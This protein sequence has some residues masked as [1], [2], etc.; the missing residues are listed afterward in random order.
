[1]M[2]IHNYVCIGWGGCW[3]DGIELIV[4]FFFF[5][6]RR[7]HTRC[8][9]VTGVQTCAL[10]ICVSPTSFF[11]GPFYFYILWTYR[12]YC[13][14]PY[15]W[16]EHNFQNSTPVHVCMLCSPRIKTCAIILRNPV[17]VLFPRYFV[18]FCSLQPNSVT[19]IDP[20][21]YKKLWNSW[22]SGHGSSDR[23]G[24]I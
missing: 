14:S 17:Y 21:C 15:K 18:S 11:I 9:D 10:P 13:P 8:A 23:E 3:V 16:R 1:M 12:A 22:K 20:A 7:R 5:S 24:G 19:Q 2:V 4:I 6:S